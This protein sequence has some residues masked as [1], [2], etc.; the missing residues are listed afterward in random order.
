ML[1]LLWRLK[2][3]LLSLT[4]KYNMG[5]VFDLSLFISMGVC[6]R[7]KQLSQDKTEE[8]VTLEEA[9]EHSRI[10]D[11]YDEIVIRNCLDA[12]HDAVERWLNRKIFPTK[13]ALKFDGYKRSVDLKFPPICKVTRVIATKDDDSEVTLDINNKDYRYD[14]IYESVYFHERF[15]RTEYSSF[16]IL[17]DCG[18][19]GDVPDAIRHAIMMT[20]ATLYENRE[21]DV[22][23]TSVMPVSLTSQRLLK[24]YRN[25]SM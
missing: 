6:M 13:M 3:H 16:T 15:D 19:N 22:V 24:T 17:Y 18:Y 25:R 10:T 9:M 4:T 14:S 12:A 8:I 23:G 7:T 21:N 2:Q 1:L 5:K 20:F 11:N